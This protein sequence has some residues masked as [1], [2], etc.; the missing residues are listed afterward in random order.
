[1]REQS[2]RHSGHLMDLM[3]VFSKLM[4]K[5]SFITI[6]SSQVQHSSGQSSKTTSAHGDLR[7]GR[8]WK[9]GTLVTEHAQFS[10]R[11]VLQTMNE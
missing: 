6:I 9:K 10:T 7:D 8:M 2:S 11:E 1:M 3:S 5:T 4:I